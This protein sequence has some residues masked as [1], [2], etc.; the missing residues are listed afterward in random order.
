MKY[1]N[2]SYTYVKVFCNGELNLF[3]RWR[4][5]TTLSLLFYEIGNWYSGNPM[6]GFMILFLK[7]PPEFKLNIV[8]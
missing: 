5:L 6:T 8:Y 7:N 3:S 4:D 1:L 2:H